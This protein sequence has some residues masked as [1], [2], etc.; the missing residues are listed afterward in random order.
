M[1]KSKDW[2]SKIEG[3]IKTSLKNKWLK[4]LKG[5]KQYVRLSELIAA[6]VK[7]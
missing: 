3:K 4:T 1:S 2:F 6:D 7:K 5:K